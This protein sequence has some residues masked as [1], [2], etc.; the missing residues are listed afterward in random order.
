MRMPIYRVGL[1][2]KFI[3][4]EIKEWIRNNQRVGKGTKRE[5]KGDSKEVKEALL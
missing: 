2:Y 1:G 5:W 3:L 4:D